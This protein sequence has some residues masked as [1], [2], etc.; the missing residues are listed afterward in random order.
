MVRFIEDGGERSDG[1]A[2]VIPLFG[3]RPPA[4]DSGRT[5]EAP[6]AGR[7]G[8]EPPVDERA[9]LHDAA[10]W[11]STWEEAPDDD[12][13]DD[14]DDEDDDEYDA[15]GAIEREVAERNLLKRLRMRQL[16]VVEAREVV[17]ERD[18]GPDE[19]QSVLD[20]FLRRGYLDDAALAEQL[21]HVGVDR[22]GQG[23][24]VIGQTLA[25][26]GIPRDI[27]D[28][29]LDALPDDEAERA[30]E[31]ARGKARSMAAIDPHAAL[32]RLA[33]QLARRGYSSSAALSAARQALAEEH[34]AGADR[35]G[36]YRRR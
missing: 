19:V 2:P 26:R 20:D 9:H 4:T 6:I 31:Y 35:A 21:I 24:Q 34:V 3:A 1:L 25:K 13:D 27:A 14:E 18:L 22:K 5:D 29:A 36:D 23:R 17:A 7:P 10:A 8:T 32:R 11:R 15:C 28:A 30:L 12:D 16:S 33:G